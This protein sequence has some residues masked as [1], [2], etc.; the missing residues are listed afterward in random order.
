MISVHWLV[1][2][3][4]ARALKQQNRRS[5]QRVE[6]SPPVPMGQPAQPR[7]CQEPQQDPDCARQLNMH[8][9]EVALGDNTVGK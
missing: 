8:Y 5:L 7:H 4:R 3:G 6:V 2:R 9:P 1:L